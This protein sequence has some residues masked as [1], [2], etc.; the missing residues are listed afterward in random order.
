VDELPSR[1]ASEFVLPLNGSI[2]LGKTA[3][4][5]E[6]AAAVAFLGLPASACFT[7]Q[8]FAGDGDVSG[9]KVFRAVETSSTNSGEKKDNHE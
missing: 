7:G 3:D 1:G 5:E 8:V 9:G 2:P 6:V 4:P